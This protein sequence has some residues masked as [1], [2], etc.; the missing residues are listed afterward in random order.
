MDW[1]QPVDEISF[2]MWMRSSFVDEIYS[3]CFLVFE[4]TFTSFFKDKKSK[5]SRKT[6][7]MKVFLVIFA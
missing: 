3:F 7:R 4:G 1:I 6:V 2:G 5:R